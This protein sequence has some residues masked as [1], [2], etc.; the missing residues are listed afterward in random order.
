M[1]DLHNMSDE[2]V[3]KVHEII[4]QCFKWL[5]IITM[6]F[7]IAHIIADLLRRT[8]MRPKAS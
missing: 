7:L 6:A 4:A 2:R 3:H 5:I 8:I 1:V